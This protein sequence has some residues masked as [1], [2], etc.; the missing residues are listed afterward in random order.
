MHFWM[1][2]IG[3]I[4]VIGPIATG[5]IVARTTGDKILKGWE[6]YDDHLNSLY[7]ELRETR[8]NAEKAI[9]HLQQT[10][11]LQ[12][13]LIAAAWASTIGYDKRKWDKET[14]YVQAHSWPLREAWGCRPKWYVET[15]DEFVLR[16]DSVSSPWPWPEIA[17]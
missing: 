1:W 12:D 9:V 11:E 13:K 2:I 14:S 10:V 7:R 16:H 8:E 15:V 17:A 5:F 3:I 6:H 4:A